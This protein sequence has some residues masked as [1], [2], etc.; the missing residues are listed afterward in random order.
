MAPDIEEAPTLRPGEVDGADR[1]DGAPVVRA[2]PL[3]ALA[4]DQRLADRQTATTPARSRPQRSG[5]AGRRTSTTRDGLAPVRPAAP[6]AGAARRGLA[7]DARTVTAWPLLTRPGLSDEPVALGTPAVA[8]PAAGTGAAAPAPVLP[9]PARRATVLGVPPA[10]GSRPA[11]PAPD[12]AAADPVA[13]PAVSPPTPTARGLTTICFGARGGVGATTIAINT[14]AALARTGQRVCLVDLDCDLADVSV[15]LNMEIP[16]SL[17]SLAS[18][19]IDWAHIDERIARHDSGMWVLSR[20]SGPVE[21]EPPGTMARVLAR[22]A[23]HFDHVVIDGVR[24]LG[25]RARAALAV[26]D[27]LLVVVGQDVGALQRAARLLALIGPQ[28]GALETSVVVR[29]ARRRE[30]HDREIERVLGLSIAARVRCDARRVRD[31]FYHSELLHELAPRSGI[32]RDLEQVAALLSSCRSH[33]VATATRLPARRGWF[34][35][36]RRTA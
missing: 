5:G 27:H 3:R 18:A 11:R 19:T 16:T 36:F 28:P 7:P 9:A 34:A 10:R 35:R 12:S 13:Q 6:T 15:A 26:A 8:P 25:S 17:L 4:A 32:A 29:E 33:Q 31:A 1:D 14:A 23:Q 20:G 30:V 24:D 2:G 21:V 22:L